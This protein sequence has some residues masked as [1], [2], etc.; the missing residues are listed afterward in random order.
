MAKAIPAFSYTGTYSTDADDTYWYIYCTGDG[1]LT[2]NYEKTID[3]CLVGGGAGG[4][5]DAGK[6][7][8]GGAVNNANG[9]SVQ[10][11]TEYSIVIGTGGAAGTKE[12]NNAPKSPKPGGATTAFDQTASGGKIGGGGAGGSGTGHGGAAGAAGSYAFDSSAYSRYGGCGG[13]GGN[14]YACAGGAGGDGGGGKGGKGANNGIDGTN[15][16][17]GVTNTGGGGGGGGADVTWDGHYQEPG[18]GGKGGSGI[19]IIRGTQDDKLPVYFNGTQLTEL[20]FNGTQIGSLVYNGTQ[21]FM[22]GLTWG[23]KKA[24]SCAAAHTATA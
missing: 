8:G 23:K 12:N 19:V 20:F 15:G 9:L 4:Y 13:G 11:G 21:V 3:A 16:A 17:N 14:I 2:F 24:L 18:D 7:G 1:V 22:R 5:A 10:A 6:G